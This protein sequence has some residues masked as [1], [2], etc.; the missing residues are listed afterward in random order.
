METGDPIVLRDVAVCGVEVEGE[1]VLVG[2][3]G[4]PGSACASI[5]FR[6]E[7]ETERRTQVAQLVR[8]E[9]SGSLLTLY[10]DRGAITLARDTIVSP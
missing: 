4:G 5:R 2:I 3:Y 10:A 7:G 1:D 6:F 9:A 8:W